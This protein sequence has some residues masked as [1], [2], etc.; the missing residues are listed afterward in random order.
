MYFIFYRWQL[1]TMLNFIFKSIKFYMLTNSGGS[2]HI[3]MPNFLEAGLSK[4]EIL[5][6]FDI[7]NGHGRHCGFFKSRNIIGRGSRY[8]SMPNIVKICQSVAK[9]LRFLDFS[10]R[11]LQPS[12]IFEIAKFFWLLG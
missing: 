8:I 7:P 6:F 4:A 9:I 1:A 10:R 2:R 3:T 12:W 5:R 11:R